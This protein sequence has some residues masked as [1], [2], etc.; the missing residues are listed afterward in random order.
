[1]NAKESGMQ[2]RGQIGQEKNYNNVS[3]VEKIHWT[4]KLLNIPNCQKKRQKSF[5]S[6]H[7]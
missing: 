5:F 7:I 3:M 4:K 6:F 2:K 1:M